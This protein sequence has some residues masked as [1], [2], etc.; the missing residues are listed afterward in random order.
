MEDPSGGS[1]L[2]AWAT[3]LATFLAVV[4]ALWKEDI[5]ARWRR[6]RL[7]AR[8]SLQPPDCHKIPITSINRKTGAV[9]GSRDAYYFRLW[10][11]NTGGVR[12]ENV[13]VFAAGLRRKRADGGYAEVDSFLPMNLLWAHTKE[14]FAPGLS[15]RMGRHC[16]LGFIAK[17][18]SYREGEIGSLADLKLVLDTEVVPNTRSNECGP[19][20]YELILR[21]AA[22][23]SLPLE[24]VCSIMLPGKWFDDDRE[25][26]SQGI[27]IQ[28][29]S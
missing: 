20:E 22:S 4:V 26:L 11:E 29:K 14:V 21:I 27:G 25:M 13:Q 28:I 15:P 8:I 9:V 16:D 1:Q 2:A 6:P 19:G 17:P 18:E 3:A 5:V 24:A 12:A 10:I 7:R 23:N